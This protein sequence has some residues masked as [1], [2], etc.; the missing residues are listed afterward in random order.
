M[1]LM[2]DAEVRDMFETNFF[3]TLNTIRPALPHLLTNRAGHI[4]ICSSC[5]AKIGIP[6][7]GTYCATKGAQSLVGRAMRH[8]L[9]PMGINVSTVYPVRT[10]SEFSEVARERGGGK[11]RL[12][13]KTPAR[14]VQTAERVAD[15]TVACLRRPRAEVWTRLST[16]LAF[17]LASALPR[18]ADAPLRRFARAHARLRP[19]A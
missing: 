17:A 5:I 19:N 3:G 15:A 4:L 14:L 18:L 7:Y 12:A 10:R 2:T 11:P 13:D 16:R 1:H 8:E 9:E 6:Y